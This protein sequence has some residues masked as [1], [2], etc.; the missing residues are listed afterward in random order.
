[1]ETSDF[2]SLYAHLEE[3]AIDYKYLHQIASL[4]QRIRDD[5]H[6]QQNSEEERKA[7]W[8]MDVFNFSIEENVVQPLF[9]GTN[10]EGKEIKYPSYDNFSD[11]TYDYIDWRLD[12]TKNPLLKARY[13]HILWLS[14]KK[15]GK[16]AQMAIDA[17]LE[18]T[19]CYEQKDKE[20][21]EEHFGLA[22][23]NA[24]KNAF[25]L[26]L[27]IKDG[28][29]LDASKAEVKRLVVD[30]NPKSSSLFALRANLIGLM[31]KEKD[32][33]SKE[34]FNG[35]NEL[36]LSFAKGLPD[37]HRSIAMLELGEKVEQ[38]VGMTTCNWRQLIAE[39]WEKM[40]NAHMKNK[41]VA[42]TFCQNALSCYKQTKNSQ[43]IEE[44]E[45][46]YTELKDS[47]EFKEFKVELNLEDHIK[48]CEENAKKIV[49]HSSEDILKFLISERKLLPTYKETRKFAEE[50]LKEHP[51][52]SIFPIQIIDERGH[53][54][55]HFTSKEEI[56]EYQ[57]LNQYQMY[58]ETQYLPLI[59][60]IIIEA[61]KEKKITLSILL[62]FLE[63]YS[64]Y[65]KTI[66]KKIQNQKV[67]H[68]W[69]SLIAPSLLEFSN[70]MEYFLSSGKYP[71]LILCVDSLVL[72]IEGLI[73][74]LCTY[75]GMTTFY[76]TTDK[77]GRDIYL[78]K[79]LNALLHDEKMIELMG[80]D[81][82]FLFKFVLVE[83]AGYNL[84]HKIAHSLM[85]FGEYQI[86]YANLLFLMLLR[87]GKFDF[88]H[89][90]KPSPIN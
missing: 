1:M 61:I 29:R 64:W 12:E 65:G 6:R 31:I 17:Y 88:Q 37:S 68:N 47:A 18:L 86:K 49:Q 42:I 4:F 70:Q 44:L 33:F 2:K 79:D 3:R 72:K 32:A 36:C 58:L 83:K 38:K 66:E 81:D 60:M 52:Q 75:S 23:L 21:P 8:E 26:A 15:H 35:I 51:L 80:E 9:T 5:M 27:N 73:R 55:Q 14:P 77:Q 82:L 69:L 84:R 16:Y 50:L 7:Q 57:T 56:E 24:M 78:E 28:G 43:K 62:E 20:Q 13:A 46:T 71:N 10:A 41:L 22:V 59:N 87:L 30:F 11:A 45:K 89:D 76:Q 53:N 19:K 67:K 39:T 40:M 34:D 54:V 25:F 48:K 63:K 90:E 85:Y 74:D